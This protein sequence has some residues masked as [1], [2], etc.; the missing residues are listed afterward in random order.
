MNVTVSWFGWVGVSDQTA[1]APRSQIR[2]VPDWPSQTPPV[3]RLCSFTAT[4]PVC[5]KVTFA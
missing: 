5:P 4:Q 3:Q 1:A 2:E